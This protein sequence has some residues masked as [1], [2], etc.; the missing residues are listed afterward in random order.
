[1]WFVGLFLFVCLFWCSDFGKVRLEII[2]HDSSRFRYSTSQ[3]FLCDFSSD[4]FDFSSSK[5]EE[6]GSAQRALS[7]HRVF[8]LCLSSNWFGDLLLWRKGRFLQVE[9]THHNCWPPLLTPPPPH[10]HCPSQP[11]VA[12]T[13]PPHQTPGAPPTRGYCW[14]T[15]DR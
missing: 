8:Q 3:G 12:H 7:A 5:T 1:M 14:R 15:T 11:I 13:R 4:A 10:R 6:T 2:M 9:D